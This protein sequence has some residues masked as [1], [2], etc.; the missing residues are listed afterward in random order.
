MTPMVLAG[1]PSSDARMLALAEGALN[2]CGP[3][4]PAAAQRLRQSIGQFVQGAGE[5]R[6]AEVRSSDEYPRTYQSLVDFT[7]KIDPRNA[8]RFC[9]EQPSRS[10]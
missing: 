10:R 7:A 9:A 6:L 1:E 8:A 4:D 3:I 5:R 2:Y